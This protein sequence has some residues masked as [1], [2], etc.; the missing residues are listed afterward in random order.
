MKKG[1]KPLLLQHGLTSSADDFVVNGEKNS[2]G[3]LLANKGYDVWL[4]NNRGCKYSL[5]SSKHNVNEA[6]FWDFS[7][8]EMGRYDVPAFLDY[9]KAQTSRKKVTYIGH[10]EGTSQMFAA[11][12]DPKSSKITNESVDTFI[13]L[14]PIVYIANG[15]SEFFNLLA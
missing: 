2:L 12:S 9:I 10:S 7:F 8:Q 6:K 4:G 5:S 1:L 14:A 13:A 3:L 11:L 15:T